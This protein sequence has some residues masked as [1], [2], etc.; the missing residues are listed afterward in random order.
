MAH[1]A[2]WGHLPNQRQNTNS[3]KVTIEKLSVWSSEKS[4]NERKIKLSVFFAFY[5]RCPD[6]MW[7]TSPVENIDLTRKRKYGLRQ[8]I[9]KIEKVLFNNFCHLAKN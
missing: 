8:K 1:S 9:C 6:L 2:V 4:N 3:K 5:V 7:V